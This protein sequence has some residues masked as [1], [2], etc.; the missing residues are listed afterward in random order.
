MRGRAQRKYAS[1]GPNG[2]SSECEGSHSRELTS[3]ARMTQA[4][5]ST[6]GERDEGKAPAI[7]HEV[8]HAH[9]A[10]LDSDAR[11]FFEPRFRFDFSRV[12]IHTDARA[13]ESA[14]AVNA[15]AYTVG[16]DIVFA[17]GQGQLGSRRNLHCS[18]SKRF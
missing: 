7:V 11:L 8:L 18:E 13:A 9:G 1:E 15:L 12:R 2:L 3:E 4:P 14:R 5:F 10:P 17:T 6:L 16:N